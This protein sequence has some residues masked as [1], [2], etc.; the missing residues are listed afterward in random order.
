MV[1]SKRQDSIKTGLSRS[2]GIDGETQMT[3]KR[4]KQQELEIV[5][6]SRKE[7][8]SDDYWTLRPGQMN[9]GGD[10]KKRNLT[11]VCV[12]RVYSRGDE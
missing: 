12:S 8:G 10:L 3:I 6:R 2:E 5:W 11:G 7:D 1:V 9:T 4:L